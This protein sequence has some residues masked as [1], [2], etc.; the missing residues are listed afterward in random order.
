MERTATTKVLFLM[1]LAFVMSLTWHPTA[2]NAELTKH[3]RISHTIEKL[4]P[5]IT[6]QQNRRIASAIEHASKDP[7]CG[8]KWPLLVAIAF[9]ESSLKKQAIGK[10]NPET[11]DFGL[12]QINNVNVVKGGMSVSALLQDEKYNILAGCRILKAAKDSYS[13]KLKY[14]VGVYNAGTNF[15]KKEV[16]DRAK[17]YDTDIRYILKNKIGYR[18]SF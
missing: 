2:R 1:P 10:T 12:M 13:K 4:Q 16:V 3:D 7:S 9:K 8:I 15:K 17:K 18:A 5:Y 11:K 14:W 6:K